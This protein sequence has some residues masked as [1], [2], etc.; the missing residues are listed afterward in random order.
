M[1]ASA[2]PWGSSEYYVTDRKPIAFATWGRQ[3][4]LGDVVYSVEEGQKQLEE[5]AAVCERLYSDR[6][7]IAIGRDG[8]G[9][10][11]LRAGTGRTACG[12]SV[13]D[14]NGRHLRLV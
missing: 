11:L 7:I 9:Y 10:T 8:K 1:K 12:H 3:C 2:N 6:R 13:H 14:V 4:G 5:H